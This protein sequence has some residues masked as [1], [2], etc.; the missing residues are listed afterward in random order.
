MKIKESA[1]DKYFPK[2]KDKRRG[3]ALLVHAE[4]VIETEKKIFDVIRNNPI[5]ITFDKDLNIKLIKEI[6]RKLKNV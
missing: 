4:A 5:T 3:E 2:G 1:L 6:E